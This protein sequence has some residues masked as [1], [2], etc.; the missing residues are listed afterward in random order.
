[1][2]DFQ[3]PK[4]HPTFQ[5]AMARAQQEFLGNR[6]ALAALASVKVHNFQLSEREASALALAELTHEAYASAV[7]QL[8]SSC[9]RFVTLE[10]E[11]RGDQHLHE[12]SSALFEKADPQL[13]QVIR[14]ALE[15]CSPLLPR[16]IRVS[17]RLGFREDGLVFGRSEL[18]ALDGSFDALRQA[19]FEAFDEAALQTALSKLADDGI[20]EELALKIAPGIAESLRPSMRA[21][22]DRAFPGSTKAQRPVCAMASQLIDRVR[23]LDKTLLSV[24]SEPNHL[25][26]GAEAADRLALISQEASEARSDGAGLSR[27]MMSLGL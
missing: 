17:E 2:R 3:S 19:A 7:E 5:R 23:H 16:S 9:A 1:M 25:I 13:S 21:L 6:E 27:F 4:D 8:Y 15:A 11:L 24:D 14:R 18:F 26:S 12:A 10:F 22:V 20:P